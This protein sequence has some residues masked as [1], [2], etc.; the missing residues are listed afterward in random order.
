MNKLI[1]KFFFLQ[2]LLKNIMRNEDTPE[3]FE[4]IKDT[5]SLII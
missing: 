3:E 4:R 2:L 1:R 5:S